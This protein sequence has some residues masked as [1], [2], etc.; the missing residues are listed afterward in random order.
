MCPT[1]RSPRSQ[2]P[3]LATPHQAQGTCSAAVTGLSAPTPCDGGP[4]R[5]G[6]KAR[7]QARPAPVTRQ[8]PHFHR[9]P[10]AA[11]T[12]RVA[13]TYTFTGSGH[14]SGLDLSVPMFAPCLLGC[15]GTGRQNAVRTSL[16]LAGHRPGPDPALGGTDPRRA[17]VTPPDHRVRGKGGDGRRHGAYY[18]RTSRHGRHRGRYQPDMSTDSARLGD[19]RAARC[20][21]DLL[22]PQE[23]CGQVSGRDRIIGTHRLLNWSR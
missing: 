14:G 18:R 6:E 16:R 23:E 8:P 20:Q 11:S 17:I 1:A 22:L 4:R 19:P 10:G 12:Y 7:P 9:T 3:N 21:L 5:G 2:M 13:D 15:P